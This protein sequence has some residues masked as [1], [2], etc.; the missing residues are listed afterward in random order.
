MVLHT[1][2]VLAVTMQA[3]L[4]VTFS[5]LEKAAMQLSLPLKITILI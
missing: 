5:N 2:A 3:L 4:L 1:V